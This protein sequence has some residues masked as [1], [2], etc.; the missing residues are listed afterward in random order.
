MN[1][2]RALA[3]VGFFL[4]AIS[5]ASRA[6]S[7]SQGPEVLV[8]ADAVTVPE[9]F[10]PSPGKP[11][12]YIFGQSYLFLGD[13]VAGVK[14]PDR[15]FIENTVE[16]ELAKQGFVRTQV[17]GPMPSIFILAIWGEAT[18]DAGAGSGPGGFRRADRAKI[19]NIVGTRKSFYADAFD[20]RN[21]AIASNEDRLYLSLAAFDAPLFA[22]KEKRLLWRTSMS[23]DQRNDLKIAL[24]AMLASGAPYFGTDVKKPTFLDDRDRRKFQVEIGESKV[25]PDN[26]A[27][28]PSA[29]PRN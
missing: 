27:I 11:V 29:E 5:S 20:G 24:P 19:E 10:R 14:L 21:I 17:G 25:V 16:A 28:A 8:V 7:P 26:N 3:S 2:L 23:I 9:S 22:K 13:V 1:R 12:Y 15:A 18:F 4:G 6:A